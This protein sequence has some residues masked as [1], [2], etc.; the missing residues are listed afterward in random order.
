MAPF[1]GGAYLSEEESVSYWPEILSAAA[2]AS[3]ILFQLHLQHRSSL[4]LQRASSA[5][6][7]RLEIYK[8]FS[9]KIAPAEEALGDCKHQVWSL[10]LNVERLVAGKEDRLNYVYADLAAGFDRASTAFGEL[11]RWVERYE[12]AFAGFTRIKESIAVERR[13]LLDA[14]SD[15]NRS[16]TLPLLAEKRLREN[17]PV[18]GPI[19]AA[20]TPEVVEAAQAMGKKYQDKIMDFVGYAWDV[21]VEAQNALLGP[22]FGRKLAPRRPTDPRVLVLGRVREGS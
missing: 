16:L 20:L 4:Q 10:L 18:P 17:Q 19:A 11:V 7:L 22:V 8:E 2:A 5:D 6:Q 12:I 15:F 21:R 14:Y 1:L 3:A 13:S 9:G